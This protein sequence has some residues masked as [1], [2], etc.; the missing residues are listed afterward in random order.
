MSEPKCPGCGAEWDHGTQPTNVWIMYK[1]DAVY[2]EGVLYRVSKACLLRQLVQRDERIKELEGERD[3][4]RQRIELAEQYHDQ[5]E[6]EIVEL[7]RAINGVA[8][9]DP[10]RFEDLDLCVAL[11]N[12]HDRVE[13]LPIVRAAGVLSEEG[14]TLDTRPTWVERAWAVIYAF[15]ALTPE[16]RARIEEVEH[17]CSGGTHRSCQSVRNE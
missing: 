5:A 16:Q 13:W 6:A 7:R 15:R 14:Q 3:S 8:P 1:C 4:C 10:K 17:G 11:N 12:Y 9:T 2:R